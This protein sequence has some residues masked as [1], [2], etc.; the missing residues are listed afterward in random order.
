MASTIAPPPRPGSAS[1]QGPDAEGLLPPHPTPPD[2]SSIH[3]RPRDEIGSSVQP[4]ISPPPPPPPSPPEEADG[5][6]PPP[7]PSPPL[8]EGEEDPALGTAAALSPPPSAASPPPPPPP[9]LSEMSTP[10]PPPSPTPL[11]PPS[12]SAPPL[13][14]FVPPPPPPDE[15]E[16]AGLPPL[17]PPTMS[18]PPPPPSPSPIPPQSPRPEPRISDGRNS[19]GE[20]DDGPPTAT[21]ILARS[22]SE[23]LSEEPV[24][25]RHV[26]TSDESEPDGHHSSGPVSGGSAQPGSRP[27]GKKRPAGNSMGS[28]APK[29]PHR[30]DISPVS[31]ARGVRRCRNVTDYHAEKQV[32]EGQYGEVFMARDKRNGRR[33]ALKKLKMASERDGFP[34]TAI[35]EIKILNQLQHQNIVNLIEIVTNHQK[36]AKHSLLEDD[37]VYMVFEYMDYDLQGLI[38]A[39]NRGVYLSPQHIKSYTKQLLDGV[40][41]M[42]KNKIMHRD[43]KGA[44]ILVDAHGHLKIADWGLA[45]AYSDKVKRYTNPVVTLW[46]RAPELLL[47]STSYDYSIDLWSVGC[48]FAELILGRNMLPGSKTEADQLEKIFSILGTPKLRPG[49]PGTAAD[50]DYQ[51]DVWPGV[52]GCPGWQHYAQQPPRPRV[53]QTQFGGN[54]HEVRHGGPIRVKYGSSA[55]VAAVD[56][57]EK[58]LTLDPATRITAEGALD[59]DYFWK[60]GCPP[61]P[62]DLPTFKVKSVHELDARKAN[63]ARRAK[64]QKRAK[65]HPPACEALRCLEKRVFDRWALVCAGQACRHGGETQTGFLTP[66]RKARP[67]ELPLGE[68]ILLRDTRTWALFGFACPVRGGG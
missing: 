11:P 50:P 49:D 42:H 33:V 46:F 2:V 6:V 45:I 23:S 64:L 44:N 60:D 7:P 68:S 1:L 4:S 5:G 54:A 40:Y 30:A 48:I 32:G 9:L 55:T 8:G 65:V 22:R 52:V 37:S 43:L 31:V 35:R 18:P 17:P 3:K 47:G 28:A 20:E 26:S 38:Y 66:G 59:H 15:E 14:D 27:R 41:A 34:I 13:D 62:E 51:Y 53:L 57:M 12:T 25:V 56:L 19:K 67:S 10:L 29:R 16:A 63:E 39:N 58:L 61:K 21:A 24:E 36:G